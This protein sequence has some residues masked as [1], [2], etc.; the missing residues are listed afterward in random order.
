MMNETNEDKINAIYP[1]RKNIYISAKNIMGTPKQ[2]IK[3]M[4]K[5]NSYYKKLGMINY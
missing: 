2:N 4:G 3:Q 5:S 1:M